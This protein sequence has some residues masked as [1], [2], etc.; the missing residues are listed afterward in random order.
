MPLD[1]GELAGKEFFV[2]LGPDDYLIAFDVSAQDIVGRPSSDP[3][4]LSLADRIEVCSLVVTQDV[5]ICIHDLTWLDREGFLEERF[6]IYLADEAQSLAVFSLSVGES[7]LAGECSDLRLSH[8]TER[9]ERLAELGLV[10]S[11]EE[12]G[13]VFVG[14]YSLEEMVACIILIDTSIVSRSDMT[15]AKLLSLFEKE[16]KLDL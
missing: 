2:H 8:L 12:V 14:I 3:E 1:S 16:L 4:S 6:H 15:T 10:E 9:K 11:R 13:L 7:Y 5:A